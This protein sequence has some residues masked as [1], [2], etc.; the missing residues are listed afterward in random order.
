LDDAALY[1]LA[2]DIAP[3]LTGK[4]QAADGSNG[5]HLYAKDDSGISLAVHNGR[6]REMVTVSA[7]LPADWVRY[8]YDDQPHSINVNP[9]RA[10]GDIA[11]DIQRRLLPDAIA[12][13]K[14]A[15]DAFEAHQVHVASVT[16]AI[17]NLVAATGDLFRPPESGADEIDVRLTGYLPG[18]TRIEARF[19][20]SGVSL[21][22][23][24]LPPDVAQQVVTMLVQQLPDDE[25]SEPETAGALR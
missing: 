17:R 2:T 25:A 13:A 15:R 12:Y 24:T 18:T 21:T 8:C 23:S 1:Q 10:P 3:W 7:H 9:A 6:N 16:A 22:I 11:A 4:W 20:I 14:R 19:S 5:V